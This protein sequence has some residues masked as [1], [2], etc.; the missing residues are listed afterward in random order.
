MASKKIYSPPVPEKLDDI[1]DWL[2]ELQIWQCVTG[3]E[4]KKQGPI[5]YVSPPDKIHK[6]CSDI[7]V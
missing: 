1:E 4:K 5:V 6:S 2:R 7:K 3:I